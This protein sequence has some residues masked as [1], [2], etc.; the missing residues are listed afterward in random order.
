MS[1]LIKIHDLNSINPIDC[2]KNIICFMSYAE[3]SLSDR[4]TYSFCCIA[5]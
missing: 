3:W 5:L 1:V 4:G 2:L